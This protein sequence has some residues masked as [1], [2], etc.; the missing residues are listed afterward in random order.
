MRPAKSCFHYY[1]HLIIET[2]LGNR[3]I[4]TTSYN[5]LN[6]KIF[7]Q[8]SSQG[9]TECPRDLVTER[10]GNR[11]VKIRG[12]PMHSGYSTSV[13]TVNDFFLNTNALQKLRPLKNRIN[14]KTSSNH[15][16]FSHGRKKMREKYI[17]QLLTTIP[18]ICFMVLH[19]T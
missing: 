11:E 15:K 18:P 4:I 6:T 3:C 19:K 12:N 10:T 14:V 7:L 1:L 16:Q 13:E 17:Q 2:N 8:M 5:L 9:P